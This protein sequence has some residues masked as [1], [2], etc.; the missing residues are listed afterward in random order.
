LLAKEIYSKAANLNP[1][2]KNCWYNLAG[3]ELKLGENDNACEHFY[4][5]YLLNDGEVLELIKYN[6]PNFRNGSIMSIDDVEEKPKFIYKGK[7]YLF[8][9]K[10]GINPKYFDIL[11][12]KFKNSQILSQNFRGHL[13]IQFKITSNDSLDIKIYGVIGDEEKVKII[14]EEIVS[15]FATM[16]K[17][18]SAKNKG[19]NVDLWEKWAIPIDSK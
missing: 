19:V 14:K 17:Y 6:C 8:F 3:S 13:Y 2:D 10:N 1:D 5:A 7:E 12:N 16:V 11:K 4:Q 18:V 15:I 9:E